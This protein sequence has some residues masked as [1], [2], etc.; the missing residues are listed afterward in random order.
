[1]SNSFASHHK[2][3]SQVKHSREDSLSEREFERLY[4]GAQEMPDYRGLEAQ[5][6]VLVAGR[7]GFRAGEIA[8][9]RESW[10]DWQGSLIEI[11]AHQPC[12][13]GRDGGRCG[14]CEQQID[15]C[16]DYHPGLSRQEIEGEWWRPKTSAAVRGVP[17]DWSPRVGLIIERF[18]DRFDRYDRSQSSIGRRLKTAA[19][20]AGLNPAEVYPHA[21]RATAAS[22]Q[23]SRGLGP[24]A[25]TSMMGW[26]DLSTAQCYIARS[27][28]NTRR[29]VRA[30]HSR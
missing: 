11:P 15:Q 13:S 9:L 25:L 14:M 5:F 28:Q 23:A 17:W 6:C 4:E 22:Y 1:M 7:L 12:I 10:L 21:L 27:A 24:T 19:E 2:G 30:A 26:V 29:A 18:F 3:G 8:H 16:V 20:N